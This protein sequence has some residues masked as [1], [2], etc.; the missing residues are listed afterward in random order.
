MKTKSIRSANLFLV[1]MTLSFLTLVSCADSGTKSDESKMTEKK[2]KTTKTEMTVL[3]TTV[4]DTS[5][6]EDLMT[7]EMI[8]DI[9]TVT[10]Y[11]T[12]YKE[13]EV[14]K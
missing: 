12:T 8:M 6:L 2:E 10:K 3:E 5:Y 9:D 13:V 1:L 7:G 11:D 14:Q 4:Y